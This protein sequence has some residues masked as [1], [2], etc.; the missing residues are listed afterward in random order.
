MGGHF[1]AKPLPAKLREREPGTPQ[2]MQFTM[3]AKCRLV[4]KCAQKADLAIN[5]SFV[6]RIQCFGQ[7]FAAFKLQNPDRG[8]SYCACEYEVQV[9]PNRHPVVARPDFELFD[10][11]QTLMPEDLR[12]AR[13]EPV[14]SLQAELP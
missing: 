4:P 10:H 13:L 12:N 8:L 1:D 3:D 7:F 5:L 11:G 9:R 14:A 2:P 6:R